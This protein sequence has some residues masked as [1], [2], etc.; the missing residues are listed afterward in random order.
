MEEGRGETD[1]RAVTG[2]RHAELDAHVS[3]KSPGARANIPNCIVR[4]PLLRLL[5]HLVDVELHKFWRDRGAFRPSRISRIQHCKLIKLINARKNARNHRT[6]MTE[7]LFRRYASQ[8]F[9]PRVGQI[10]YYAVSDLHHSNRQYTDIQVDV[11]LTPVALPLNRFHFP[12]SGSCPNR[13]LS[14]SAISSCHFRS[15]FF[16]NPSLPFRP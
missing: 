5:E 4:R 13:I 6:Y 1:I 14:P 10:M 11:R 3:G 2:R 12:A 16:T 8:G 7:F 9:Y 15:A